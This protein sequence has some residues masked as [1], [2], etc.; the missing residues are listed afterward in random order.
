MLD[1]FIKLNYTK[2]AINVNAQRRNN[3]EYYVDTIYVA[4]RGLLRATFIY[5]LVQKKDAY[6]N[7]LPK[8]QA[9]D[10][11]Q[12]THKNKIE[13]LTCT[14]CILSILISL[15]I[16]I[17]GLDVVHFYI[18]KTSGWSFEDV[19]LQHEY[20]IV[21]AFT[22]I[23]IWQENATDHILTLPLPHTG[24]WTPMGLILG[25]TGITLSF[26]AF[27][28][29]SAISDMFLA[30]TVM[31]HTITKEMNLHEGMNVKNMNMAETQTTFREIVKRFDA[32][33]GVSEA[34]NGIV[35]GLIPFMISVD[36]LVIVSM[37]NQG[38][39]GN[40]SSVL[41]NLL[42]LTKDVIGVYLAKTITDEVI[43][44]HI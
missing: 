19:L 12:K 43:L 28:L 25:G 20:D 13:W 38:L 42:K 37:L 17:L 8:M 35:G 4:S 39:D 5:Q 22:K 21:S 33:M 1:I 3:I 15:L 27:L 36:V 26:C 18:L 31:L 23:R 6:A 14:L 11:V 29:D 7:L 30:T 32:L 9:N 16:A 10:L 44:I 34:V 40:W 2:A 24:G 41:V